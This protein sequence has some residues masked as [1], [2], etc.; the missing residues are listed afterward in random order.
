MLNLGWI[1]LDSK[2]KVAEFSAFNP[3]G[4]DELP[5]ELVQD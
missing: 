3:I 1:P 4:Y 2:P 5:E